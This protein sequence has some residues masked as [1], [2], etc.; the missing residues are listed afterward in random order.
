M[1]EAPENLVVVQLREIRSEMREMR[2]ETQAVH[3]QQL[4][5]STRLEKIEEASYLGIG[6]ATMANHKLDRM[7]ERLDSV[8]HRLQVVESR[9]A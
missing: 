2:S 6:L 7:A 8:D 3:K 1:V 4:E 9:G 5:Q